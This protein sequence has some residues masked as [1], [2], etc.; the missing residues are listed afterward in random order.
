VRR[1]PGQADT[2]N[3]LPAART[4]FT[5]SPVDAKFK[6]VCSFRS[7]SS[8]V[9]PNAGAALVNGP[10]QDGDDA[11]PQLCGFLTANF[12]G[13]QGGVQTRLEQ[14]FIRVNITQAG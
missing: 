9:I 3:S 10:L 7:R 12:A 4:S 11:S 6:L 8:D 2:L 1:A 5:R 13:N 14:R